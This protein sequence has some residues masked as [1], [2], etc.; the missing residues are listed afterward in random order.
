MFKGNEEF[1]KNFVFE[2]LK[3]KKEIGLLCMNTNFFVIEAT[4]MIK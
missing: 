1:Y 3:K 2:N 4:I